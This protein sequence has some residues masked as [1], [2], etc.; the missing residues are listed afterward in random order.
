M[1]DGENVCSIDVMWGVTDLIGAGVTFKL[2]DMGKYVN[3]PI[4][5]YVNLRPG[6][7]M[8]VSGLGNGGDLAYDY[9][10]MLNIV[11]IKF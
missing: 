4:V 2:V 5:K 6:A 8:G 11:S 3:F 1:D 10:I 7:Y 9:G